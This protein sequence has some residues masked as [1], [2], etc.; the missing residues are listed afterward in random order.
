MINLRIAAGI[1]PLS[2]WKLLRIV[3]TRLR[4][5]SASFSPRSTSMIL[6]SISMRQN[7]CLWL[8]RRTSCNNRNLRCGSRHQGRS[9]NPS[10]LLPRKTRMIRCWRPW[11]IVLA[12]WIWTTRAI[13]TI[14]AIRPG[15][16]FFDVCGSNWEL[17]IC[18][19]PLSGRDQFH[20]CWKAPGLWV[21][22]PRMLYCLPRMIF[23][24]VPLPDVCVT[25]PLKMA[26]H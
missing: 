17:P 2:M 3:C 5:S 12:A 13:G 10:Q 26:A 21:T 18:K 11:S 23:P 22:L 25:T 6:S 19:L 1:L 8:Q 4:L 20:P 7:R 15:S 9:N 24:R 16:F 14:T